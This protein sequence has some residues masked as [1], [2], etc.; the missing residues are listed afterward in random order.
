MLGWLLA[1]IE[2]NNKRWILLLHIL[3]NYSRLN[4]YNENQFCH[5]G[6]FF[7]KIRIIVIK[8]LDIKDFFGY[9]LF[10][11]GFRVP[12]SPRLLEVFWKFFWNYCSKPPY[13]IIKFQIL[14]HYWTSLHTL[15]ALKEC[16]N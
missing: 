2:Q 15:I 10:Y 16:R 7:P 1:R 9:L 12:K 6:H 3:T 5:L 8:V 13:I 11:I 4:V 14:M